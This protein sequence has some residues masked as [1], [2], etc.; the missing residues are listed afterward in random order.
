VYCCEKAVRSASQLVVLI[1]VSDL[2]CYCV[3]VRHE[4]LTGEKPPGYPEQD[5]GSAAII[6]V[7]L[8]YE[9]H[10]SSQIVSTSTSE[11]PSVSI[12]YIQVSIFLL[13]RNHAL[14][15]YP[16]FE[17]DLT[18]GLNLLCVARPVYDALLAPASIEDLESN[19]PLLRIVHKLIKQ[20][21]S[22]ARENDLLSYVSS[23]VPG[24]CTTIPR[25]FLEDLCE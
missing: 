16:G 12:S 3:Y 13:H 20:F 5:V 10:E 15:P 6:A 11:R 18:S 7:D 23:E 2:H 22:V 25:M 24:P 14:N 1:E 8:V 4:Y 21:N 19:I 9:R 17:A